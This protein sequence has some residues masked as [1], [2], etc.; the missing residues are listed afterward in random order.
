VLSV[1]ALALA[2]LVVVFCALV[3][4]V[5]AYDLATAPR[6]HDA[7]IVPALASVVD[8]AGTV[9]L[10]VLAIPIGTWRRRLLFLAIAGLLFASAGG[11]ST[12]SEWKRDRVGPWANQVRRPAAV[13]LVRTQPLP[14]RGDNSQPFGGVTS[15]PRFACLIGTI[16]PAG[17]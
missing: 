2:T 8:V 7:G 6:G 9:L 3:T 1:S 15:S 10:L 17:L 4:S 11:L 16:E 5:A 14:S 13:V 12:L